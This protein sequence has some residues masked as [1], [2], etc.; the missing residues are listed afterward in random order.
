MRPVLRLLTATLVVFALA[1]CSSAPKGTSGAAGGEVVVDANGHS[2]V[3]EPPSNRTVNTPQGAVAENRAIVYGRAHDSGNLSVAGA[4]IDILGTPLSTRTGADGSFKFNQAPV[5]V[6]RARVEASGFAV[7]EQEFTTHAGKE[8]RVDLPLQVNALLGAGYAPH[9]HDFWGRN[10]ERVL[11]DDVVPIYDDLP[12]TFAGDHHD[13]LGTTTAATVPTCTKS[14][15]RS[16]FGCPWEF[17]LPNSADQL[18]QTVWPGTRQVTFKLTWDSGPQDNLPKVGI[19]LRHAALANAKPDIDL[20]A[21]ANGGTLTYDLKYANQTD[22][23]HQLFTAWVFKLYVANDLE[24]PTSWSPSVGQAGIGVKMTI[25]KGSLGLDP[26]HRDF[27]EANTSAVVGNP[28]YTYAPNAAGPQDAS[29]TDSYHVFAL[30]SDPH[31]RINII[32]PGTQKLDVKIT[33]TYREGTT[34]LP[35]LGLKY[36]FTYRTAD[37]YPRD[38]PAS[39]YK[40]PKLLDSAAGMLHYE[41][42]VTPTEWDG[43]YQEKSLW[44]FR[45]SEDDP[46]PYNEILLTQF[47]IAVTAFKDPNF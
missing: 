26:G 7:L 27:W 25:F 21:V 24:S 40:T 46:L 13:L 9:L 23:G 34:P 37:Q 43:F 28:S 20:G 31:N 5:G 16:N 22:N 38:T 17:F 29:A 33:W 4:R 3:V 8:T 32:A 39:A 10:T 12:G 41:I 45:W 47:H 42:P 30:A 44:G 6:F 36:K 2:V 18:P 11:M 14:V 19:L 15:T 35:D 1:G